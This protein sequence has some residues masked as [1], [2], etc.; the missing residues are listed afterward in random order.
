MSSC[1]N[2]KMI[3]YQKNMD[4]LF[5]KQYECL[6]K[7]VPT[8]KLKTIYLPENLSLMA[9]DVYNPITY[10]LYKKEPLNHT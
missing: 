9:H 6:S 1:Y 2:S 8:G 4:K 3:E 10:S 5:H 7:S